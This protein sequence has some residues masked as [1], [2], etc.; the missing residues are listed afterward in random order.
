MER[1]A[2][3]IPGGEAENQDMETRRGGTLAER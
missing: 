2:Q 3:E 1:K